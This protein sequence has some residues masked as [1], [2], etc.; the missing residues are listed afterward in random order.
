MAEWLREMPKVELHVHLD[1]SLRLDTVLELAGSTPREAGLPDTNDLREAVVPGAR[2]S[3]EGYLEA[4]EYTIPLLQT[5][6]ALERVA[7]ELCEDAAAEG[8][9]H[10]EV[11]FAPLLHTRLDLKPRDVVAAVLAGLHRAE[12]AL[13][14]GT[15]LILT[16][17]KQK[18]TEESIETVQLAA[19]FRSEGVVGFDLAGPEKLFSPRKH[20]KAVE[21]AHDADLNVTL[22]AGEGCCPEQIKEAID[23]GAHRIG[24]GVYLFQA[25]RTEKRVVDLQT[26]LELCPTSNLQVSGFMKD[27]GDHPLKRYLDLGIPVTINTD[28]RLMSR[29]DLTREFEAMVTAFDLQEVEVHRI[30]SNSVRASF[31]PQET[32]DLL[33]RRVDDFFAAR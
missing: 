6:S 14:I 1:G 4:F 22:H 13:G 17:L 21:F 26:P 31:V 30:V 28:N 11:R 8:V 23:L 15:G 2:A 32:K 27:Y 7:F 5:T 29:T 3:L 9:I 16:A 10:I 18:S 24:H 25:P 12:S 19:Q 33:Q 20:R